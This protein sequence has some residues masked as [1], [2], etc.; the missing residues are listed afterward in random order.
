MV[1]LLNRPFQLEL[2]FGSRSASPV[3]A[4][5]C[6]AQW[7]NDNNRLRIDFCRLATTNPLAADLNG[8][9]S[10][11]FCFKAPGP[12]LRDAGAETKCP[13]TT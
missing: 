6:L 3:R 11:E 8:V 10:P 2:A 9:Q 12:L 5:V 7:I 4:R 13:G 1:A